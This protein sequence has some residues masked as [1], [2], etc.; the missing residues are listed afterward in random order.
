MHHFTT[1]NPK[2]LATRTTTPR[3]IDARGTPNTA[4]R[5]EADWITRTLD[6]R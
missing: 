3:F 1:I 4:Q 6:R 5:R 2:R